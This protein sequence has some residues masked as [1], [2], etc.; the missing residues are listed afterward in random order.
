MVML[1]PFPSWPSRF[2]AGTVQVVQPKGGG[3]SAANPHLVFLFLEHHDSGD[4]RSTTKAWIP[5]RFNER[6]KEAN[7]TPVPRYPPLVTKIVLPLMTN[8]S[9]SRL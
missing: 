1:N 6:S 8:S 4:F 7:S 3:V 5:L 2:S 9:P